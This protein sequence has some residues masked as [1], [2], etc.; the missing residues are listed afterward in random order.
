MMGGEDIETGDF[1]EYKRL[2]IDNIRTLFSIT[3]SMKEETD[4]KCEKLQDRIVELEKQI[5]LLRWQSGLIGAIAA[6]VAIAFLETA[7]RAMGG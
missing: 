5:V 7:L 2:L 1:K 3:K 4:E 6:A